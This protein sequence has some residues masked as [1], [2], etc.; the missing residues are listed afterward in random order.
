MINKQLNNSHPMVSIIVNCYNGEKYLKKALDSIVAQTYNNW[1]VIF[2]DDRS[3]DSSKEI[4]Q[5]YKEK[6][7][8]YFRSDIK[9]PLYHLR[10]DAIEHSSGEIIGF[11]DSDD[12]WLPEKLE[13][14]IYHFND[15][16][17]GIVYS[18][19]YIYND[20]TK[21]KIVNQK[22]APSGFI[23]KKLLDKYYVGIL[24]TLIR[25]KTFLE[26]GKFNEYYHVIGD[27]EFNLRVSNKIKHVGVHE[28]LAYYRLHGNNIS[29]LNYN[30]ETIEL[31]KF[32]NEF[33]WENDY[34]L[35]LI[36]M[37]NYILYRTIFQDI[38]SDKKFLAFKKFFKLKNNILKIKAF[39]LILAPKI[40]TKKMKFF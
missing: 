10:N 16:Q 23:R 37:K 2:W 7:F 11:L 21:K 40:L 6:R 39:I 12:W 15:D 28:L 1:E 14:Q 36:K 18:R 33:D 24:T 22:I 30:T 27:Y 25:K 34:D 19:Y 17:V 31:E 38:L 13:K 3:S 9:K 20:K 8:K 26:H 32:A 5:S 29:L 4:L 35:N